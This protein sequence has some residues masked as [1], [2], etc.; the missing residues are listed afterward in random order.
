MDKKNAPEYRQAR[1]RV[2]SQDWIRE[3]LLDQDRM[4]S[5]VMGISDFD[6]A[7]CHRVRGPIVASTDGPYDIRLVVKSALIHAAT[8]VVVKGAKPLFALDN[9]CGTKKDIRL[10]LSELSAQA[11]AMEIP[12]IA[13]NTKEQDVSPTACI[14]VI[15]ELVLPYP[16]RDSQAISGDAIAVLGQPIWGSQKERIAKAKSL[17]DAWFEAIQKVEIH[18]AKD[19]TKGGILAQAYEMQRKSGTTFEIGKHPFHPTR[20]LDNFI[21]ALSEPEFERLSDVFSHFRCPVHRIGNVV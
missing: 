18:A 16:I 4:I 21:I 8:D 10:M 19:I 15:G 2:L 1:D 11:L 9:L 7:V 5:P 20:N 14:T 13:G 12:L 3:M 17:F 6:D